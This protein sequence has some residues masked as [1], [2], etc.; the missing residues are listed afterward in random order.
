M[1]SICYATPS[2]VKEILFSIILVIYV[3]YKLM[4]LTE[5]V[6]FDCQRHTLVWLM[7]SDC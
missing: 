2:M 3:I 4:K 1:L 5:F 6:K 7:E